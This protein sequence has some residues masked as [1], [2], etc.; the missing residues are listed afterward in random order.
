MP[1]AIQFHAFGVKPMA[2]AGCYSRH[3]Y[4][5]TLCA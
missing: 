4:W 5:W 2:S 3:Q 1:T